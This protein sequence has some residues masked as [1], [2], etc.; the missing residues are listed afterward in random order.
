MSRVHLTLDGTPPYHAIGLI[1]GTSHDGISAAVVAIDERQSPRL[2][3]LAFKAFPY[4]KDLR[5]RLLTASA[6][7]GVG[8]S[9]IAQLNFVLGWTF[10][11]VA[12]KIAA[13]AHV[14]PH[15]IDFIGS[16]GHTFYHLPPGRA[17]GRETPSTLQLGE[18]AV[19]AAMTG[20]PV[21]ADFRVMDLALGGEAAPLAP[22]AH[23]WLFG[24]PRRGRIVQNIG[25]IGNATYL[26]PRPRRGD[27]RVIAFDT[28]PGNGMIDAL[29]ARLTDGRA[30]M[31]RNGRMA[32]RGKIAQTLLGELMRHP[33][34]RRQP[35]K[36]TG[37][38]E[39]S[40]A[41]LGTILAR[42]EALG[43]GEDD[44]VATITAWTARSIGDAC[45]RFIMPLG[46]IDQL[47][48]TGGGAHNPTLMRMIAAELPELEVLTAVRAG[49]D[50]DALEAVA[51]AI[52]GYQTLR[53]KPGNLQ[54][55]TGARAA[56]ILGKLTLPP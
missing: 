45:R 39:F 31:D 11:E 37:R 49:V 17:R 14:A 6:G 26:P 52:L 9:E 23:L 32:A 28:G 20:V 33:Y 13:I 7:E 36:S 2:R 27:R 35:P 29:A 22:L 44:L 50:G 43:V 25:G 38:E 53:G 12:L 54:S 42:A 16:H 46:R 10:G 24:D 4:R 1:S 48:A 18:S 19:I 8:T 55:V 56:A 5:A 3:L 40:P 15:R 34:F 21:L 30:R 41:H 51:F 47:I